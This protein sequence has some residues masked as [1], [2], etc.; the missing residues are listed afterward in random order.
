MLALQDYFSSTDHA[1]F[2]PEEILTVVR[3]LK[4]LFFVVVLGTVVLGVVFCYPIKL[5]G[6]PC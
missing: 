6:E 5:W 3:M 2:S 1:G 4:I